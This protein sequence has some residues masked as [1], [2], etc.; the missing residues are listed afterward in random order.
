MSTL[1]NTLLQRIGVN[2]TSPDVIG[3]GVAVRAFQ[4]SVFWTVAARMGHNAIG[5]QRS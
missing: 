2:L 4:G 3:M 1:I 5:L